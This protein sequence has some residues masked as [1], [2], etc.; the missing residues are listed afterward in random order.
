[1]VRLQN[2]MKKVIILH[3]NIVTISP[4]IITFAHYNYITITTVT[5]QYNNLSNNNH[6]ISYNMQI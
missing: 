5:L 3:L 2:T 1:M 4:F 6:I